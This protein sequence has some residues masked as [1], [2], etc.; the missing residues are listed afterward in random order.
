M[1]AAGSF[2]LVSVITPTYN[3][4]RYIGLCIQSLQ[5][6]TYPHWEMVLI[7]DG[8]SDLT[9]TIAEEVAAGDGRIRVLRQA[10]T[11]IFRLAETYNRALAVARGKYIAVLEGDDI[12]EAH[13][14]ELQVR[15][16]EAQPDAAMCWGQAFNT[17]ND[18]GKVIRTYPAIDSPDARWYMND[19]AGSIFHVFLFR[20]PIPALTMLI[21][22]EALEKTGGFR[23]SCGLPL[24][25]LP[26]LYE[27]AFQGKFIFIP[28]PLGTW[29]SYP[30]QI[31]KIHT[32][33]MWEGCR[34]LA[35]QYLHHPGVAAAVGKEITP[36]QLTAYYNRMLVIGYSR[37]GRYKLIRKEFASARKDYLRSLLHYG[38]VEPVWKLRS[39]TGLFFSLFRLDVEGLARFLGKKAYR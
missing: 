33:A 3:H 38:W 37:S 26:T 18:D 34:C 23:Q 4:E 27:L 24:V 12:W 32:A 14:L 31:T 28:Q 36:S 11:G 17:G 8:S 22:R 35:M 39:L 5:A 2:P 30:T 25:D 10:N 7:D 20:N 1:I 13:K 29:R 21:R 15:A 16:M 19:P 6:Q 9:G